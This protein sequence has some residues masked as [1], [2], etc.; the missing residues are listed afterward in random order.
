[1]NE[2]RNPPGFSAA[3]YGGTGHDLPI[4]APLSL[5]RFYH[6]TSPLKFVRLDIVGKHFVLF[7]GRNS[8][9]FGI[10][11]LMLERCWK[12]T[13]MGLP[14]EK[15]SFHFKSYFLGLLSI[16]VRETAHALDLEAT[17]AADAL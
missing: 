4:A 11:I 13:N 2:G 16:L 6:Y 3:L 15:S 14:A 12:N 10:T 5:W 9:P 1:M 7:L 8:C 17:V